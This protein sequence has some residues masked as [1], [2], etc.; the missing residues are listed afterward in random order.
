[1]KHPTK[2]LMHTDSKAICM[3]RRI[4]VPPERSRAIGLVVGLT[5]GLV[6]ERSVRGIVW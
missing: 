5:Y 4:P 3:I 1:M 6:S 2:Q